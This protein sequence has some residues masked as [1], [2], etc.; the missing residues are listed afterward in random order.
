MQINMNNNINFKIN[1]VIIEKV[2]KIKYLWFVTHKDLKF[3]EH[4]EY[5]CKKIRKKIEFFKRIRNKVSII[6]AINIHIQSDYG[7]PILYTCFK[8]EQINKLQELQKHAIRTILKCYRFTSVQYMLDTLKWT[9]IKKKEMISHIIYAIIM[10]LDYND[11]IL[12]QHR[13][14]YFSKH[15]EIIT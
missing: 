4:L 9:L 2:N 13:V 7:S 6:T 12:I 1:D 10:N 5:I 14:H 11:L 8:D 3:K 15:L